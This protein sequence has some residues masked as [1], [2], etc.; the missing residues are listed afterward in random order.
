M[1]RT[2][3]TTKTKAKGKGLSLTSKQKIRQDYVIKKQEQNH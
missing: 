2:Q 1:S 3:R